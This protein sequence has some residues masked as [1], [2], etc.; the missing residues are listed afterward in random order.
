[1]IHLIT[2]LSKYTMIV[3]LFIYTIVSF[4]A[5]RTP[6][7]A[8]GKRTA[9]YH[10]MRALMLVHFAAGAAAVLANSWGLDTIILMGLELLYLILY[11]NM[12]R[13]M[14]Q[15][16]DPLLLNHMMLFLSLGFIILYRLKL[17]SC[18][19]QSLMVIAI[20]LATCWLPLFIEKLKNAKIPAA[21]AGAIGLVLLAVVMVCG[22]TSYG[23]KM[24]LD[25]GSVS[26]QPSELVKITYVLLIA[27]L[28][29]KRND[30]KRVVYATG[31]AAVHVLVLVLSKDLGAALIYFLA[32]LAMLQ[33][34]TRK[35]RYT[36]A[37]LLVGSAAAVGAY[38]MFSHVR[39]RVAAWLDPWSIIDDKG[40]QITQ[41][42][43]AI[44]N[45][46]FLGTGLFEG[47]PTKIPVVTKDV[48]FSAIAEELGGIY[49]IC[50]IFAILSCILL[51]IQIAA[52][53]NTLF[54][55]ITGLGFA[56]IYGVQVILTIGGSIKFI[57]ATGVTL[58]F[59]SYGG[60]SVLSMFIICMIM[61]GLTIMR[62]NE[63]D[64][65]AEREQGGESE[66]EAGQPVRNRKKSGTRQ[67][68]KPGAERGSRVE[69]EGDEYVVYFDER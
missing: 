6:F 61:L 66:T 42:L 2:V 23:A 4:A 59:I 19:K 15:K 22:T 67:T 46:G 13:H 5:I 29:R 38:F 7:G 43:F 17:A 47:M 40:Y 55:K 41:S 57:P 18:I 16:T 45:G 32:Y 21:V 68:A 11:P 64:E 28:L 63:D 8:A 10:W 34:A 9:A 56:V 62:R 12:I 51:M 65:I 3:I 52:R 69:K 44:G 35:F 50:L 60:S 1:M 20:S 39:E 54:Y 53:M 30:F 37:G 36:F 31:V 33:V 14:Y 48:I 26:I 24:S 58:P 27:M 49:A 25:I